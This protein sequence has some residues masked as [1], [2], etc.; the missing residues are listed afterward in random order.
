ME[1]VFKTIEIDG[2]E[3]YQV[4]NKGRV[5]SNSQNVSK[6]LKPQSDKVGYLHVRLYPD[7]QRFGVYPNGRGKIPKLE[8]VHRLVALHFI[9]QPEGIE[10]LTV[11]HIDGD[12]KNNDVTNLEWVSHQENIQHSW[13]LGLRDNSASKAA[14]KRWRPIKVTYLDGTVE[15]Y[16]SQTHVAIALG[17][18]PNSVWNK[19]ELIYKNP[20]GRNGWKAERI[21]QEDLPVGETWKE[22]VDV[23]Y[24]M[25][26]LRE[27]FWPREKMREYQRARRNAD[28]KKS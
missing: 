17:V 26:K 15:Y 24:K 12:K 7:D 19:L 1:E 5:V 20:Y 9:P 8:K 28:K 13:D 23:E 27:R 4:S 22:I 3:R 14:V 6:F 16:K 21:K 11:N 10:F 25:M 2:L 18:T